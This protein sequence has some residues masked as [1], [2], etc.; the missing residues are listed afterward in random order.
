M[1]VSTGPSTGYSYQLVFPVDTSGDE[2]RALSP[3]RERCPVPDRCVP[4]GL[5]PSPP[6][7]FA[8]ATVESVSS[9]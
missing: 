8:N 1:F 3:T 7:Q 4:A 2:V 6:G 5:G 9:E